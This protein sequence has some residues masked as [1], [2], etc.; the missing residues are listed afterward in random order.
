MD[1]SNMDD[2]IDSRQV[3]ERIEEL[4]NE[5]QGAFDLVGKERK[6]ELADVLEEARVDFNKAVTGQG[7]EEFV[8]FSEYASILASD[9]ENGLHDTA[10]EYLHICDGNLYDDLEVFI[11]SVKVLPGHALYAEAFEY[12]EL[13]ALADQGEDFADWD[14]GLTLVRESYFKDYAQE[15]AEEC[16]LISVDAKWPNN[17]IDWDQ[18]ARELEVDYSQIDYDGISY[19][20][21]D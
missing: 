12:A 16:G 11:A 2:V 15:L 13:K 3:I 9:P 18:A 8:D 14:Y 6:A 7:G 10:I 5:L 19:F 1:I 20:V 21:R 17:C 4:E